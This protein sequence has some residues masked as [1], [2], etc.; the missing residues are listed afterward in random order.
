METEF[1]D[2]A[3]CVMMELRFSDV[4]LFDSIAY[5]NLSQWSQC[6][7]EK[8]RL[9]VLDLHLSDLVNLVCV[10]V[11]CVRAGEEREKGKGRTTN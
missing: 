11:H 1:P 9:F 4:E 2:E 7:Y 5:G 3:G 10:Y 6:L 8:S